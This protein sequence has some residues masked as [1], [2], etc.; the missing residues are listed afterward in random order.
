[1]FMNKELLFYEGD[2]SVMIKIP[3]PRE[4]FPLKNI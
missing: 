1:M 4:N 2:A 3:K